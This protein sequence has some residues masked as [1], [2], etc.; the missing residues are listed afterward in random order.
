MMQ[1]EFFTPFE[2]IHQKSAEQ[3]EVAND[4]EAF[5]KL[6]EMLDGSVIK[7]EPPLLENPATLYGR[8]WFI[9][10]PDGES[11]AAGAMI[12]YLYTTGREAK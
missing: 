6:K 8:S 9:T 1:Y 5:Q 4:E 10:V 11:P 7:H 2:G 3:F 12:G